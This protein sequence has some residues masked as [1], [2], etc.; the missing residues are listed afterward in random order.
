[1]GGSRDHELRDIARIMAILRPMPDSQR[2]RVLAY[3]GDRIDLVP[4]AIPRRPDS[5]DKVGPDLPFDHAPVS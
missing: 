1:M 4:P 3:V 5:G 2:K